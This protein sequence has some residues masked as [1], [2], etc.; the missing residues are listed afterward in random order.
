MQKKLG[1]KKVQGAANCTTSGSPCFI[2]ILC[3]ATDAASDLSVTCVG[4]ERELDRNR[5][6]FLWNSISFFHPGLGVI[7]QF[8]IT[9]STDNSSHCP[10]FVSTVFITP[11]LWHLSLYFPRLPPP[12]SPS[13]LHSLT[14]SPCFVSYC[15]SISPNMH[16][17]KQLLCCVLYMYVCI[18]EH[19]EFRVQIYV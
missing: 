17:T 5:R 12:L 4:R 15:D 10:D 2:S 7:W 6:V 19:V 8:C 18:T 3:T 13:S 9:N 11:S 16:L 1:K 14:A